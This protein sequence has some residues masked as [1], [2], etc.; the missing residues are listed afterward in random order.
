MYIS[1]WTSGPRE[2]SGVPIESAWP[3]EWP[4]EHCGPW[5]P[6]V[7]DHVVEVE[8]PQIQSA[9]QNITR[10]DFE[11]SRPTSKLTSGSFSGLQ[12]PKMA[13][14]LMSRMNPIFKRIILYFITLGHFLPLEPVKR[15]NYA[16]G[17]FRKSVFCIFQPT[18]GKNDPKS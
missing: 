1:G 9:C 17:Q 8:A 11:L 16:F 7:H 5:S 2:L 10:S 14:S 12:R 18:G 15:K 6:N 4:Q 13:T 3:Q